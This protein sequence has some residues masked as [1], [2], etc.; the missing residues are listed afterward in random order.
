M[1]LREEPPGCSRC[2]WALHLPAGHVLSWTDQVRGLFSSG[3][4]KEQLHYVGGLLPCLA[5]VSLGVNVARMAHVVLGGTV[6]LVILW[7]AG[8]MDGN[9]RACFGSM[10]WFV[11]F[12]L[13]LTM[14]EKLPVQL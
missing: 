14:N 12:N 11:Q 10:P 9:S 4:L 7:V 2:P 5:P 8:L 13:E 1:G 6:L 3:S